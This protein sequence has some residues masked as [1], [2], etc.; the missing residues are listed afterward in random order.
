MELLLDYVNNIGAVSGP[1]PA[2]RAVMV[3]GDWIATSL[4][5]RCRQWAPNSRFC[6]AG[7]ATESAIFSIL[8]EVPHEP[9]LSV[10]IPY[11][12]PLPHQRFYILDTW[13][14]PVSEGVKGEI[15]IAGE[16]LARG[17]YGDKERTA[18][19]F[20]WHEQLQERVYRTGDAGRFLSDGNIEFMGRID[21][22]VKI[23]GYRIELG[24]IENIALSYPTLT[25]CCVILLKHPQPYLAAYWVASEPVDVSALRQYLRSQLPPY[26]MP[27]AFVQLDSMPLTE[28]GKI[29]RKA[30]PEPQYEQR[31]FVSAESGWESECS[32]VWS[33]LLNLQRVSVEDNFFSLGGNSILAIQACYQISRRLQRDVTLSELGQHPTIESF[34]NT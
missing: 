9:V 5:E 17:Y 4:P 15:Y 23:N 11:G 14:R 22:Q 21:Q 7:G 8:Y 27:K 33:G 24:E 12:K 6:S 26:M 19:S 29:A 18:N 10:S 32:E 1:V 3:G 25:A 20:F 30:L 16:G 31:D 13:L 28:N 2:L 34:A